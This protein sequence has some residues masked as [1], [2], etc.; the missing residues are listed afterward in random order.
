M[1]M[2]SSTHGPHAE[3]RTSRLEAGAEKSRQP[4]GLGHFQT[5][6]L[7][8]AVGIDGKNVS[9][10]PTPSPRG[11]WIEETA[12]VGGRRPSLVR[13]RAAKSFAFTATST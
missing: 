2:E 6:R 7:G 13:G 8:A 9:S 1:G 5:G 10:G 4:V 12:R 11:E 3:Q